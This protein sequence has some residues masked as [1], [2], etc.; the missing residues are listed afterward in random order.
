MYLKKLSLLLS[1]FSLLKFNKIQE[2]SEI[3]S[4][5]DIETISVIQISEEFPIFGS[6]Y[7]DLTTP[8]DSIPKNRKGENC[9][10]C[11]FRYG[12][13]KKNPYLMTYTIKNNIDDYNLI[14]F[15][16]GEHPDGGCQIGSLSAVG[17][18]WCC[19]GWLP[20]TTRK[21]DLLDCHGNEIT[22]NSESHEIYNKKTG[23]IIPKPYIEAEEEIES[24]TA[25]SDVP[26]FVN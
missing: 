18:G 3:S 1:S 16:T 25:E 19:D 12:L 10:I 21:V 2:K 20:E 4:E 5:E 6:S 14:Q 26:E 7:L 13:I 8:L 17:Y 22:L 11:S 15:A 23:E 24:G 9:G